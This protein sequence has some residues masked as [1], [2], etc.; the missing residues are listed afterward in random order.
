M[1]KAEGE[2]VKR[3]ADAAGR[4]A[5]A[6]KQE[7]AQMRAEMEEFEPQPAGKSLP[8]GIG[9]PPPPPRVDDTRNVLDERQKRAASVAT[10]KRDEAPNVNTMPVEASYL[11]L[12]GG[13]TQNA[14]DIDKDGAKARF[15]AIVMETVKKREADFGF[16]LDADDIKQ[17]EAVLRPKYCGK[18]GLIGPC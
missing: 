5:I 12:S 15:R 4:D 16:E 6:S 3:R 13:G 17:V 18:E 10:R 11:G 2:K 8:F 14:G 9:A 7:I 1:E